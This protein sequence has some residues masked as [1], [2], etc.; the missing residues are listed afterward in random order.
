M[1]LSS[2]GSHKKV[3]L[4]PDIRV[5]SQPLKGGKVGA[6]AVLEWAVL[7]TA[8][9]VAIVGFFKVLRKTG[10]AAD[11]VGTGLSS[12]QL[13]QLITG[14][15]NALIP[16]AK[17]SPE[18]WSS[19][20]IGYWRWCVTFRACLPDNPCGCYGSHHTNFVYKISAAYL[21]HSSMFWN[22][23]NSPITKT[24][25]PVWVANCC[26]VKGPWDNFWKIPRSLAV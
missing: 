25:A 4:M 13:L 12:C 7:D 5:L 22:S 17:P 24:S 19:I 10:D 23:Q 15:I 1:L 9:W 3:E 21:M 20:Y 2:M 18:R 14:K 8:G 26:A 11:K 6:H 16:K